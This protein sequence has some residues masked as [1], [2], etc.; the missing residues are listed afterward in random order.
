M[1]DT[2]VHTFEFQPE[3]D[4]TLPLATAVFQALGAAS[5]CWDS[6][7]GTGVFQSERA[8]AIGD[9]LLA[10]IKEQERPLLGLA[11]TRELLDELSTRIEIDYF[12]G[13]GGL[14][15]STV[16]GRPASVLDG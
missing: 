15:Y 6:M 4:G 9:A 7:E 3:H 5:V 16:G 2:D 12:N 13:G 1:S 11:T 14:D 10:V 8:K